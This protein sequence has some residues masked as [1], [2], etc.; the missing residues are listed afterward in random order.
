MSHFCS[1][2]FAETDLRELKRLNLKRRRCLT[3]L[4]DYSPTK[5]VQSDYSKKLRRLF[6]VSV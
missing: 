3:N 1:G 6:L 2:V 5:G 4:K